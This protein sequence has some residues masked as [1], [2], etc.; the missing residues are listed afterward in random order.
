MKKLTYFLLF[1]LTALITSCSSCSN[2][3]EQ[4]NKD[5]FDIPTEFEEKLSGKDTAEVKDLV[6]VLVQHLKNER[7]YDAAGMLYRFVRE[8]GERFP[9]LYD[10][11]DIER[12][13]KVHQLLPVVDYKIE[14]MRFRE[15]DSNEVCITIIMKRGANGEKDDTSKMFLNP[16]YY[17]NKWCLVMNDTFPGTNT[18]VPIE[19]RDSMTN[20][21]AQRE[22]GL[23]PR[24]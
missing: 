1:I 22:R 6:A 24:R 9:Q 19:K 21:Y 15:A 13:V 18:I 11:D 7:Y 20:V 14:Y 23:K 17:H 16:I 4:T 10:N 3:Q 12:F 5:D 2:K 8:N